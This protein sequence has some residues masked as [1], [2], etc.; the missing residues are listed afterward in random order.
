VSFAD[1]AALAGVALLQQQ[2]PTAAGWR[3]THWSCA[4][5]AIHLAVERGYAL[6][7][8][9][10]RRALHHLG[11]V[12]KRARPRA[13]DDDPQRVSKLATIR[14]LTESLW[15]K[16]V[17]V[18]AD[19][20]DIDLLPKI[21]SEWMPKGRRK[22]VWTPGSNEKNYLAGALDYRSGEMAPVMGER[23][24][25]WL[26]LDLLKAIDCGVKGGC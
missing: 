1:L 9:T 6:S 16:A 11:N 12:W 23:K 2:A 26:F 8:E 18:F 17:L 7:R 19:D 24:N 10:I 20:L 22:E 4:T 25:R 14:H 15:A 21:G 13:R 3:R 5:L